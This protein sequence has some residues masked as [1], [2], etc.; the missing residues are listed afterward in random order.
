MGVH[1][2]HRGPLQ[3]PGSHKAVAVAHPALVNHGAVVCH[4]DRFADA[5]LATFHNAQLVSCVIYAQG[6]HLVT[7]KP[8]P[9]TPM[10]E[11]RI[12]ITAFY[13]E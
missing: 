1:S 9:T 10:T 5:G 13:Q 3:V 12:I 2:A 7:R 6:C 8:L 11:V 4:L